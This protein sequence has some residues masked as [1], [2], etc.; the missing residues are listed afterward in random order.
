MGFDAKKGGRNNQGRPSISHFSQTCG[1]SDCENDTD[2]VVLL[3]RNEAGKQ[4]AAEQPT[5]YIQR[6]GEDWYMKDGWDFDM[7]VTR[8]SGCYRLDYER[9]TNKKSLI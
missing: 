3:M 7:W 2:V 9:Y 6:Q 4:K 1:V 5:W 8:C